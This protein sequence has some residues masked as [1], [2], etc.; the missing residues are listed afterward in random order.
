M[1]FQI[2]KRGFFHWLYPVL[3][4]FYKAFETIH[5]S[6][7]IVIFHFSRWICHIPFFTFHFCTLHLSHSIFHILC[8]C[9]ILLSCLGKF[10]SI[11][12]VAGLDYLRYHIVIWYYAD[13]NIW[14]NVHFF[15][16]FVLENIIKNYNDGFLFQIFQKLRLSWVIYLTTG[17]QISSN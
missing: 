2:F 7:L 12:I 1:D 4:H 8:V 6:H 11:K 9:S 17:L 14:I 10:H 3:L 5:L 16:F 13:A 15:F